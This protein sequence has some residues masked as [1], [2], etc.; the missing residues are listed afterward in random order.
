[1]MLPIPF[2]VLIVF[3]FGYTPPAFADYN[4]GLDAYNA[5]DYEGAHREWRKLAEGGDAKAQH[6]M[7]LLYEK[8][9]GIAGGVNYAE[10]AEWYQLAA[11][12]GF[13]RAQNNLARLYTDGKGVPKN[14]EKAID[15]WRKAASSGDQWAAVNLGN[16][17]YSGEG[18]PKDEERALRYWMLAAAAGNSQAN[19]NLGRH[20]V[21]KPGTMTLAEKYLLAAADA[22]IAEAQFALGELARLKRPPDFQKAESW[23]RLAAEKYP[24]ARQSLAK[25]QAAKTAGG[26]AVATKAVPSPILT[27]PSQPKQSASKPVG[28]Q[29]PVTEQGRPRPD[30]RKATPAPPTTPATTT[31]PISEPVNVAS[32]SNEP[33]ESP[34]IEKP[35]GASAP[36]VAG[37][38]SNGAP[39]PTNT[40]PASDIVATSK[41]APPPPSALAPQPEPLRQGIARIVK[42]DKDVYRLWL[43]Q[44]TV[45]E[46]LERLWMER[47][48]SYSGFESLEPEYRLYDFGSGGGAV[49]RLM[50]GSYS[51]RQS[52]ERACAELKVKSSKPVFCRSALN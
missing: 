47:R 51:D 33:T 19:Y 3:L 5:G 31:A 39:V 37:G 22:G 32:P 4:A 2:F 21:T 43:G 23:Y 28:V 52:A 24:P 29:K 25:L 36:L 9:K 14:L 27:P 44:D 46:T 6:G 13:T 42:P 11:N 49:F 48:V 40:P 10:A 45:R 8:G 17:F 35:S 12:Q 7:G 30:S 1:M 18:V 38:A 16:R 41:S 20:Y 15:L 26:G 34:I 50:V